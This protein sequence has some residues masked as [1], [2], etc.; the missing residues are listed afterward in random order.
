VKIVLVTHLYELAHQYH[1]QHADTALFLRADRDSDGQR[2][3]RITEAEPLPT[4]Y[5]GDL[6]WRTFA[7]T[8]T[9]ASAAA[10]ADGHN[11]RH[12]TA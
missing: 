4:S 5:G 8:P 11:A 12:P 2:P 3:F 1:Q 6:C 7:D 10:V 9:D